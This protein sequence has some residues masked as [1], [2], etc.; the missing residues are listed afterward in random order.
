MKTIFI[1]GSSSGLGKATALLFAGRGWRVIATMRN[2]EKET[3]LTRMDNVIVLPLD[4]SDPEQIK[5]SVKRAVAVGVDVVFNNAGFGLAGPL[6]N[7]DE[8]QIQR[9]INTNL[10]GVIFVTQAFIPYFRQQ[11]KGLFL[12]A[13][14]IGGRITFPFYSVYCAAKWGVEGF[15]ESLS[16]ELSQFGIGVKTIAP[17]GIRSD[18]R[19]S[20]ETVQNDAYS[21]YFGKV[22]NAF[23]TGK[24][25]T[26]VSEPMQIAEVVYTAATDGSDQLRYAAGADANAYLAERRR[27]G[28]E[29]FRKDLAKLFFSE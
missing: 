6:E 25:P 15:C 22:I 5:E 26:I 1:T 9:Q 14:S 16:F 7:Y 2:P 17:G 10:L 12:T 18:F 24:T 3:K 13:T 28:S 11:G 20:S 21:K 27:K 4:V 29:I 23:T 8:G 19:S